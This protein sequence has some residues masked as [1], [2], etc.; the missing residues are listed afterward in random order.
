MRER[1]CCILVTGFEPGYIRSARKSIKS[2]VDQ[3]K[4]S[5]KE[6]RAGWRHNW[7]LLLITSR[8]LVDILWQT[9]LGIVKKTCSGSSQS[10]EGES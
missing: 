6:T 1:G 3:F 9:H 10:N 2:T 5:N 4:I 8:T 7:K